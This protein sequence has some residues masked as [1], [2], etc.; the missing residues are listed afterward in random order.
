MSSRKDGWLSVDCCIEVFIAE[1]RILEIVQ[2][3]KGIMMI[4][5]NAKEK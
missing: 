4:E 3:G 2:K 1:K 5:E